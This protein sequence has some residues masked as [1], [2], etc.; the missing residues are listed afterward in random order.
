MGRK[1]LFITSDQQRYDTLGCNGGALART[2]VIDG[3]AASGIRYERAVPQSVVC[4]PSR[5]T[6]LTG[7]HPATH[8]VWMNG[9]P[10]PADAPS[11]ATVLH[12]DGFRTAL[13]GK[14]HFEPFMDPLGRFDENRLAALGTDTTEGAA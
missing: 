3:L 11:V 4:M 8:G 10:L 7:Q 14:A 12:R 1:I 13:V 5:S 9:I 2:P 6:M